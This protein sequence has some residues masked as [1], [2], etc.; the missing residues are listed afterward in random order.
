MP[1]F[2]LKNISDELSFLIDYNEE[3]VSEFDEKSIEEIDTI[4]PLDDGLKMIEDSI[5]ENFFKLIEI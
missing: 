4:I 5:Q 2:M 3:N 1:L